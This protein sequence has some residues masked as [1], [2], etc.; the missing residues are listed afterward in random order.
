MRLKRKSENFIIVK[1]FT[2]VGNNYRIYW[3]WKFE[4]KSLQKQ[5]KKTICKRIKNF[6]PTIIDYKKNNEM[7]LILEF[8]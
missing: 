4:K 3:Q 8:F 1:I 7:R 2:N 5:K 6:K